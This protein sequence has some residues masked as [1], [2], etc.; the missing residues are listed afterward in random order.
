MQRSS[1]MMHDEKQLLVTM[2]TLET[3]NRGV[4]T[5]LVQVVWFVFRTKRKLALKERDNPAYR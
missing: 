1:L 4:Y 3:Y 5:K 2:D